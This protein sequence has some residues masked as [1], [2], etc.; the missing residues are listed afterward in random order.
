[1]TAPVGSLGTSLAFADGDIPYL[2]AG[3]EDCYKEPFIYTVNLGL[4]ASG[5]QAPGQIAVD[6]GSYFAVTQQMATVS[7][8][9]YGKNT[10]VDT[11][12]VPVRIFLQSGSSAIAY[13][14]TQNG[15]DIG[16]WF[17]VGMDPGYWPRR[18]MVWKPNDSINVVGFNIDTVTAYLVEVSFAGFKLFPQ[19]EDVFAKRPRA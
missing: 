13:N 3:F 14:N 1:V 6:S 9:P 17:G 12:F 19:F 7:P 11:Q 5:G 16:A 4:I 10:F 2:P 8:S 15:V 18:G